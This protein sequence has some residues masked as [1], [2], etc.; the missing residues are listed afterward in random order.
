MKILKKDFYKV[1]LLVII[2]SSLPITFFYLYL[3]TSNIIE[4]EV[5]DNTDGKTKTLDF[6]S[7]YSNLSYLINDNSQVNIEK[8]SKDIYL[9]PEVENLNCLGK[10]VE[11]WG[12]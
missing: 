1:L 10:I 2:I 12:S 11:V 9:Y 3:N 6:C 5:I 4:V 8:L 7:N